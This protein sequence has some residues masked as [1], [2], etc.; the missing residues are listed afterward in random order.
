MCD[1]GPGMKITELDIE[2]IL[3]DSN[4]G[5][6]G[7]R[8]EE[9][10]GFFHKLFG[11]KKDE[12]PYYEKMIR[13]YG[14]DELK[15]ELSSDFDCFRL[16]KTDW[17][18]AVILTSNYLIIPGT[19]ILPLYKIK[20]FAIYNLHRTPFEQYA[21]DRINEPYDPDYKSE[22]EGEENFELDRFNIRLVVVE[23]DEERF[24]YIFPMEISDRKAFRDKLDERCIARDYS[25]D[26]AL[27]GW[28]DEDRRD[29]I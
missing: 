24:E 20:A 13:E 2:K 14:R 4:K 18:K 16:E 29:L 25:A 10:E 7:S 26:D 28:F 22:Y 8:R 1:G 12:E 3:V 9:D 21:L 17:D 27:E 5:I 15:E 6:Y 23:N 19:D 11:K